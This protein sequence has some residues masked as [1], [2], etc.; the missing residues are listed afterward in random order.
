M[1]IYI[2]ANTLALTTAGQVPLTDMALVRGDKMP[3]RIVLTDGPGNPSNSDEVP[4]LAVKKSLGDDSLVLAATG[5]EHVEDALGA[6]YVGSLSVNTVQLAEVMGDQSRID[7]IGE[8]VLVA[9]DGAQRTSRLIRVTVRADLLPGDYAPP[10]EVL[11][12]WSELVADA[13]AAQLP[14]ALKEAGVELAAATGQSSLSSGDAA[15]TWT[16]VGGYAFTWGDEILAGH[17]PDS[18]RL[19][20]ISTVYFFDDPALNQYCL[21]VWRLTDGAYSLIGTSAYVS[22]LS[23]GQT[24]T[25]VFTPGVTLQRGDKIIIQVCEGTEMTPYALGMH[26]VL[27]PSVPGRGLVT[28]VAT[29]PAVNGTM[30]PLMTVVV[31]YDD[32]ITLG[33]VELATARQ[34]D[35]L[36]RDV[37]QSSATA[38][39]AARTAGQS[40]ATASTAA[41]NAATSATNAANSATAAA[42]AL[43][44]IPQVDESGNMALPGNITAVGGTFDGTVNANGG[45]NI[46]LAVGAPTNESGVNRLY[47]S[48]LAAVTE[49]FASQSFLSNFSLYGG[50]VAVDQTVPGQVWKL[51]KTSAD[52]GTV[53]VNLMNPF[54]GTSNYSGWHG[55]VQP[56]AL[57][58]AGSTAARKLTFA[59]GKSG[60]VVKKTAAEMDMFTLSPA[61]GSASSLARFVDVTFYMV[62]DASM[63]PAGY[64][65]RVRELVYD[66]AQ[67]KWLCYETLSVIPSFNTNPSCNMFLSYQ[68][69]RPGRGVRAG[70]WIG[71]NA[72]DSRRLLCIADMHGVVDTFS[73]TGVGALY[74]DS[75][76]TNSHSYLGAMR[77][78]T[79]PGYNQ[80]NG[81]YDAFRALETRLI[82]STTVTE[83]T[84]YE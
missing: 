83:F 45:V 74:W 30:A 39:A 22:N 16:I 61:P 8:V 15:D 53:Q 48:G 1:I 11:A 18:C 69:D 28:E 51:S 68:Q 55:F 50:S 52:P 24:A 71:S 36:G 3:L 84:P 17:L 19:K 12:D 23:S 29:P 78:M 54:L 72:A 67:A 34:L 20:S 32:G 2:D 75:D 80:P 44:A 47:A 81:A 37:R 62:N 35:S 10:D 82:Q 6:A 56:V 66:S 31:D 49:A 14:D 43:A 64:P 65:V 13:L 7:L 79:A 59:L 25:W 73:W 4:V 76:G 57:G 58:N 63:N 46:P 42:N 60:N 27:T 70:L 77:Q 33:G 40:A 21:R 9:P 41:D 26:A 38:E 5:L